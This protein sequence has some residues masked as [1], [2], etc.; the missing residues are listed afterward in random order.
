MYLLNFQL[1]LCL[2]ITTIVDGKALNILYIFQ[3]KL[4]LHGFQFGFFFF[5]NQFHFDMVRSVLIIS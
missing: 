3:V 4:L 5:H 2:R 1:I